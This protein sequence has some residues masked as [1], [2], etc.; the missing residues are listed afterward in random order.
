MRQRSRGRVTLAGVAAMCAV[1]ALPGGTAWAAGEPNPYAFD[2]DAQTIEGAESTANAKALK[3]GTTYHSSI[4]PGGKLNYRVDLDAEKNAYVSVVAVPKLG[5]KFAYGDGI[6]VSLQNSQ[7]SNCS[8]N[9]ALA[10]SAAF[11][12]PFAA[13]AYRTVERDG[14]SCQKAGAYNVL[15]ERTGSATS[16]PEDWELEIRHVTEPALKDGGPTEAPSEWPSA[17]PA[18][19][20]GGSKE[21]AGG[22]SFNDAAEISEG[23]W[24]SRMKAGRTYFYRVPVDWG[25][26]IFATAAI[27]SGSGNDYVGNALNMQLYNP[28]RG[29][30]TDGSTAYDGKQKEA[31]LNPLPEVAYENRYDS[32]AKVNGMRFAGSYYLA[33]S[34]NP[35]LG[36]KYGEEPFGVTLRLNVEGSAKAAP[37]YV[38]PLGDFGVS[39]GE[40]AE[41]S[42]TMKLVGAAGIGAGTVLVLGLGAWMLV[43]RRRVAGQ[44]HVL[45]ASAQGQAQAPIQPQSR[46]QSQSQY[47]PP[48]A[49]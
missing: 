42:S 35:E 19:P 17:S 37:A 18:L 27:G 8:S 23:E 32:S 46:P 39:E 25:Q 22:T 21:R 43:A 40:K 3:D 11:A 24:N 20:G 36:E 2:T 13:Y 34:L 10:G 14:S 16:T 7:G 26:Q 28:V 15:V 47:G 6:K 29:F 48:A 30:V 41:K 31:A 33:V 45:P 4:G 38:G 12:R 44:P 9:H 49:W 5:T 1:A